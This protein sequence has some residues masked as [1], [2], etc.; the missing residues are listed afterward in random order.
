[1]PEGPRCAE[2]AR[3]VGVDPVGTA[4]SA[5]AWLLV[6]W[7]LPWP[8][9]A[10][11]VQPLQPLRGAIDAIGARLQ[12]L[13]PPPGSSTRSVVLHRPRR[14]VDGWFSGFERVARA[15]APDAVVDAAEELLGS[16]TGDT[17]PFRDVL[18]CAHG[19][20]DRCCGSMGTSLATA[21]VAEGI[22]VRR[23]SHTGGHRFAPTAILLPEGTT[24]AFLDDDALR[25]LVT[26]TGPLDDLLPRY[27]GCAAL[28]SPAIQAA[29]RVAFAEVGW[30]WLDHRRRGIELGDGRVRIEAVSPEGD[31][32]AWEVD[33]EPG[34]LL[35]VPECGNPPED[36]PKF[37]A[38]VVVRRVEAGAAGVGGAGA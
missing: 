26:R 24:W 9:D 28:G 23:T 30:A 4:G 10:G 6:E 32:R 12:L 22:A 29:E 25:R 21:A 13:V 19:A 27:R 14:D 18:V 3:E 38:E 31:E 34:R 20:R 7:P 15:V 37:E 5:Q 2:W 33:V 1:M 11:D 36:A 35:P 17:S 8:R 16:G